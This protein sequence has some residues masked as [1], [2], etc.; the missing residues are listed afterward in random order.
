MRREPS[1]AST[2]T[3]RLSGYTSQL[4]L[5]RTPPQG[6]LRKF[7]GQRIGQLRPVECRMHCPH[8]RQSHTASF[9]GFSTATTRRSMTRIVLS[10]AQRLADV[11]D[12]ALDRAD[13]V[14]SDR[15]GAGF[16]DQRPQDY[17]GSLHRARRNQ[18]FGDKEVTFLEAAA[19]LFQ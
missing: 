6:P 16:R 19:D 10:L 18:H 2:Q 11:V 7:L 12:V 4:P 15:F 13:D 3:Q 17:E 9:S 5:A 8:M 1:Q 14:L